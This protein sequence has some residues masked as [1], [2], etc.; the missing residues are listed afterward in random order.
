MTTNNN[1]TRWIQRLNNYDKALERLSKAADIL[2]TNKILG[3]DV[4]DLLKEGLVQRFEYTQ[5]LAWK[6]MK[7]YEEFQGYTDIQGSRD[8][9]R[10]ALQMGIIDSK[11]WME[12]IASRN[13]TSHCYDETEFNEVL[14]HIISQYL[15]IFKTF[16]IK[17]N[18]IKDDNL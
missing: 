16:A 4:D 6:V 13:V 3:D 5:E 1:D 15:P 10:K 18:K 12:T 14:N 17:M 2:S 11:M 9:I 8:A 7:D